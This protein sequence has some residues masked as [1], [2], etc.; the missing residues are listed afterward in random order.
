MRVRSGPA[1]ARMPT[2]DAYK[3]LSDHSKAVLEGK[4]PEAEALV[5]CELHRAQVLVGGKQYGCYQVLANLHLAFP[6]AA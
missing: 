5:K 6:S 2:A 3:V 4:N 1:R